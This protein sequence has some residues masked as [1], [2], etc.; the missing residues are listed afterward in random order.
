MTPQMTPAYLFCFC[1]IAIS[2]HVS[3]YYALQLLTFLD[4]D[5]IVVIVI[6]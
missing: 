1:D 6:P 5:I 4:A 2:Q 3:I